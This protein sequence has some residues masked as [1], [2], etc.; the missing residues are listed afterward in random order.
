VIAFFSDS[1]FDPDMA[2]EAFVL[3]PEP[4]PERADLP[5]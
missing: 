3:A 1:H 4:V 5:S 2:V